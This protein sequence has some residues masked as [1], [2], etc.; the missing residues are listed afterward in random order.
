MCEPINQKVD[1]FIGEFRDDGLSVL[2]NTLPRDDAE[3]LWALQVNLL[4][5]AERV[6]GARDNSKKI[7]QPQFT[8]DGPML[9]N[10]AELDGAYTE[11]SRGAE[12]CWTTTLFEMAHETVHLL[13]PTIGGT[14]YMEEGIAVYFSLML[15]PGYENYI[16]DSNPVYCEALKRIEDFTKAPLETGRLA[17]K[18]FG[19]LSKVSVE[20]LAE[21]CPTAERELLIRLAE[22][23]PAEPRL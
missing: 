2:P 12:N 13:N 21:L 10:T 15:A 14:N 11:M 19:A 3:G 8:D 4:S 17:R 1:T 5:I 16:R 6:L 18:R 20:N 22:E 7:Y 23:F 9:R